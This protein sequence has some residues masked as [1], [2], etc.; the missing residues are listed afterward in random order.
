MS[1]DSTACAQLVRDSI[2]RRGV[3]WTW[4]NLL[5]PVLVG[6]GRQ[7]ENTGQGVEVE[8]VLS[9]SVTSAL[10][11][12][13][14]R[15]RGAVNPRP[16]LL[17]CADE[18]MHSLPLFAV[19]AALAERRIAARVLGARVPH[20]ALVASI[21]RTGPSVVLVWSYIGRPGAA[22]LLAELP[23]MRPSPVVLAAGPGWGELP[24]GIPHVT[25]LVDA[26]ARIAH[27]VGV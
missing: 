15:L 7:W 14:T 5:V 2:E 1:L 27:A 4:D 20:D 23:A 17:A 26:V 25:D 18:E 13:V 8:H 6:V 10:S 3:V 12:V 22:E 21:R 11:G 16:V 9:E 24:P 19:S